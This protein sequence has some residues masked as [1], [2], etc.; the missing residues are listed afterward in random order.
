M[1]YLG[2]LKGNKI[3]YNITLLQNP[4]SKGKL[5]GNGCFQKEKV[6]FYLCFCGQYQVEAR[7]GKAFEGLLKRYFG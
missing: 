7:H 3:P 2:S 6:I 4:I 1:N 5:M